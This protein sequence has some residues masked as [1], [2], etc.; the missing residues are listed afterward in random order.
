MITLFIILIVIAGILFFVMN[1]ISSKRLSDV[2]SLESQKRSLESKLDFMV[3][4]RS[5]LR[6]EI[7]DKERELYTLQNNQEGIKTFSARDLDISDEND[8]DKI[9]RYLIQEGK[10]SLEQNEKIL[11]KME[12]L[13]MDFIAASLALGFIDLKTAQQAM[14]I[15]KVK[16]KTLNINS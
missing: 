4:Q 15:N 10:I 9:S 3:N 7:E 2:N 8:D 6:Q 13:K 12:L 16:S 14:K 11:K 1:S 5:E